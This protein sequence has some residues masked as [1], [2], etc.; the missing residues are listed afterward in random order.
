MGNTPKRKPAKVYKFSVM[1]AS[2]EKSRAER[3]QVPVIAP[4]V[5]DVGEGSQPIK[6]TAPDTLERQLIVADF[7]GQ[8]K[9][10]QWDNSNSINLLR[11]LCGDQ[12]GRVWM[13][14]KDD[15]DPAVMLELVN[16]MF[17]HF[18]AML[19]E[20]EEAAELP[21]GSGDSSN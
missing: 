5:M 14:I 13:L 3:P 17:E 15:P 10:G 12:F 21:G 11:A 20:I 1:K 4:F 7:I 16:A 2:A 8:W 9:S 18:D 6:I 19:G